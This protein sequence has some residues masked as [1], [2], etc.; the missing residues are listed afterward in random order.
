MHAFPCFSETSEQVEILLGIDIGG[1]KTA[2]IAGTSSGEVLSR[3]QFPTSTPSETRRQIVESAKD[4]G[5]DFARAGIVCGGPLNAE[6]G[7]L[8]AP[9]NLPGWEGASLVE[10]FESDLGRPACLVND[11]NAGALAEWLW[12]AGRGTTDMVFLTCGTGLGA[13][14]I[15]GGRLLCGASGNAGEIGHV[16]LTEEGPQGYGKA[17]SVEGWASGGGIARQAVDSG[18]P[19]GASARDVVVAAD[20]GDL[21]AVAILEAAGRALGHAIAILI[22]ILNP[23]RVVLGSL[24]LRAHQHLEAPMREQLTREALAPLLAD[25]LVVPAAHGESIGDMQTLAAATL[26]A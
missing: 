25:C 26:A 13:G 12:G 2:V 17:G 19:A 3:R 8:L 6:K 22:D 24:Y 9:P 15:S 10:W 14:I 21:Q 5:L 18:W 7:A 23:Q 1:T 4:F 16:R 20:A 11:A